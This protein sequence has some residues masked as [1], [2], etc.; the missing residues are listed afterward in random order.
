MIYNSHNN[1][2][3]MKDEIEKNF[4]PTN[5]ANNHHIISNVALKVSTIRLNSSPCTLNIETTFTQ[6]HLIIIDDNP[7]MVLLF[8]N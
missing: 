2:E 7:R 5:K 8:Y 4:P 6:V 3:L 1:V